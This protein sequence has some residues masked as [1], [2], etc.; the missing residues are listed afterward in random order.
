MMT[1]LIAYKAFRAHA[2]C[3]HSAPLAF[4][5]LTAHAQRGGAGLPNNSKGTG[6]AWS[7][8][9]A[10]LP[11]WEVG[12]DG[13]RGR[14]Y[15]WDGRVIRLVDEG[16]ARTFADV[17]THFFSLSILSRIEQYF[18]VAFHRQI[19]SSARHVASEGQQSV[20]QLVEARADALGA[21]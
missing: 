14:Q 12:T 2:R 9:L 11:A 10:L 19:A 3:G 7:Q 16:E 5:S 6:G 17:S 8:Q 21:L 13:E 1:E 20:I 4:A 18:F 15:A